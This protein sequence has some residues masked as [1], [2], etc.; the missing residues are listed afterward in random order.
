MKYTI[1]YALLLF[2]CNTTVAQMPALKTDTLTLEQIKDTT[3]TAE[4]LLK[5]PAGYTVVSFALVIIRNGEIFKTACQ[6][7]AATTDLSTRN[8]YFRRF[9]LRWADPNF[10]ASKIIFDEIRAKKADRTVKLMPIA[11]VLP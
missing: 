2:L 1:L 9:L 11:F 6:L 10:H 4:K 7:E 5:L 8:D 3:M